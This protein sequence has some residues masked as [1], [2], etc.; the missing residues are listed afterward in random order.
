MGAQW[1]RVEVS[2]YS[3]P[4]DAFGRPRP[5]RCVWC[6]ADAVALVWRQSAL[7]GRD[8]E[9]AACAHHARGWARREA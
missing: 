5:R 2:S 9:D 3:L 8:Y 1:E 4:F 6:R 7:T